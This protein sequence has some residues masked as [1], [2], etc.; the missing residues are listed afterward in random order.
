M[1]TPRRIRSARAA[2]ALLLLVVGATAL[3]DAGKRDLFPGDESTYRQIVREMR[4]GSSPLVLSLHG[5]PYTGKP[6]LHFWMVYALTFVFGLASTWPFV[7]PSLLAFL[8]MTLV[9]RRLAIEWFRSDGLLAALVFST[10]SLAWALGHSGRMDM[11]F[12]L[13]ISAAVLGW[14][15][16]VRTG[17]WRHPIS[18]G[19]LVGAAILVKGPVALVI[20]APLFALAALRSTASVP[21]RSA[22]AVALAVALAVPLLWLIPAVRS[23]GAEYA[24]DLLVR[25]SL[26][27]AVDAWAH[28]QPPW[29]HLQRFPATLF[30]WLPL[31]LVA[32]VAAHRAPEPGAGTRNGSRLCIGWFL[33]VLVPF[34]LFSGKLDVYMLPALTPLAL[35]CANFVE[36]AARG[37]W[38]RAAAAA[39]LACIAAFA[40]VAATVPFVS[41]LTGDYVP[42]LSRASPP[43]LAGLAWSTAAVAIAAL[44]ALSI[45]AKRGATARDL[46]LH[47]TLALAA[48]TLHAQVYFT[49]VL[50]PEL[51]ALTRHASTIAAP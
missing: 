33:A 30:P 3:W 48:V 5:R 46:L 27:R 36:S 37:G 34:S 6:P 13:L 49:L 25:Q 31:A 22:A 42:S 12:T 24:H 43:L 19:L 14:S 10:F 40:I 18:A 50:L 17:R 21:A 4:S 16:F 2:T 20:V 39:N 29:W 26:G 35:I 15:R 28:R 11:T 23:G 9:L 41:P 7:L 32:A 44:V 45:L 51:Q 38:A 1:V 8:G 47:T